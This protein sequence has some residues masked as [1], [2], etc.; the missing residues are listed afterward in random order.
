MHVRGQV[1]RTRLYTK[2]IFS[3]KYWICFSGFITALPLIIPDFFCFPDEFSSGEPDSVHAGAWTVRPGIIH[4]IK[5]RIWQK[6][7]TVSRTF[8]WG[9]TNPRRRWSWPITWSGSWKLPENQ[10]MFT[11]EI[12]ACLKKRSV[13]AGSWWK[14]IS[15]PEH[16]FSGEGNI[17]GHLFIPVLYCN[18]T[19]AIGFQK[20]KNFMQWKKMLVPSTR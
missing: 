20:H 7:D 12:F 17:T 3:G 11:A 8:W 5:H 1:T 15:A 19:G 18:F 4:N 14:K 16:L 10:P 13:P 9:F 2:N 6:I